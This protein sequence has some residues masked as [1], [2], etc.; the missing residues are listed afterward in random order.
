MTAV[1]SSP[2]A[3]Q[4]ERRAQRLAGTT[5]GFVPTMGALHDGHRS[6]VRRSKAENDRTLVSVFV[7]PTQFNDARDLAN[8]PR[9]L[10]EDLRVLREEGADFVLVPDEPSL[11]RDGYRY[12]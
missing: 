12:R 8:Y 10:D 9:V 1:V 3:W 4:E 11:Y 2:A 7:N 6:L 5:L